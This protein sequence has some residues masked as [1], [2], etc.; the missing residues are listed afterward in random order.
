MHWNRVVHSPEHLAVG[1]LKS[2]LGHDASEMF[3][4]S[5]ISRQGHADHFQARKMFKHV[6]RNH[7]GDF[8]HEYHAIQ[9]NQ[10]R[11]NIMQAL[12]GARGLNDI[13]ADVAKQLQ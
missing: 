2:M 9:I 3:N 11:Q 4:I 8:V 10:Q 5:T 7:K 1:A 6:Q 12:R 13:I